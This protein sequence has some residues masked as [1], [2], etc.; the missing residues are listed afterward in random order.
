MNVGA[1]FNSL[2]VRDIARMRVPVP[3]VEEQRRIA[4]VL[5]TLDEKIEANSSLC[6]RLYSTVVEVTRHRV[7][8]MACDRQPLAE[9]LM[10]HRVSVPKDSTTP[11]IGLDQMPRR[12]LVLDDWKTDDAPTGQAYEFAAGDL[13]FGKLR[14]NFEKAGVALIHGRCSG[15]VLALR[16][17]LPP[18]FVLG[19]TTMSDPAFFRHCVA[20]SSGTRMP[21]SEWRDAGTFKIDVPVDAGSP[22]LAQLNDTALA[23]VARV[24]AVV[25]E[26]RRVRALRDELL[27]KLVSGKLRVGE[28]YDPDAAALAMG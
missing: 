12:S 16:P 2:N 23:V 26:T 15:E 18:H 10:P 24:E 11:Y 19:L 4:A 7:H 9:V 17:V 27:P 13:L 14:P 3:P 20:V 8:A 28:D 25:A 5:G 6:E 22:E 1:V 21:R